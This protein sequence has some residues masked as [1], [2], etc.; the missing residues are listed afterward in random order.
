MVDKEN[1]K[2]YLNK[3]LK[4]LKPS[5]KMKLSIC[6]PTYNRKDKLP[7]CLILFMLPVKIRN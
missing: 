6:I 5:I 2:K 7:N 1:Y 4:I 3:I